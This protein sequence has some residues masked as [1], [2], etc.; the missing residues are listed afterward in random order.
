MV[1]SES[2]GS[3][4]RRRF[5]PPENLNVELFLEGT[6]AK[7]RD[8]VRLFTDGGKVKEHFKYLAPDAALLGRGKAFQGVDLVPLVEVKLNL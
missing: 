5:Y 7:V 6:D 1:S 3:T 8:I 4:R 2:L